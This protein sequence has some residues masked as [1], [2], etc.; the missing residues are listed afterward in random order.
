VPDIIAERLVLIN[1]GV[2]NPSSAKQDDLVQQSAFIHSIGLSTN[3]GVSLIEV[4]NQFADTW[5][6]LIERHNRDA[7][8]AVRSDASTFTVVRDDLVSTTMDQIRD[9]FSPQGYERF[10]VYIQK[11]KA[12]MQTWEAQ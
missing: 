2:A 8:G 1:L 4:A 5:H 7:A 12:F 11:Q 9:T 10:L 3:E 6:A